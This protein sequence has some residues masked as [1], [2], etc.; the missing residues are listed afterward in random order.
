MTP[1]QQRLL[2]CV[3]RVPRLHLRDSDVVDE[4]NAALEPFE[5]PGVSDTEALRRLFAEA[6][7]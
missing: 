1:A 2:I 3:A 6:K 7:Q 5:E 4:L